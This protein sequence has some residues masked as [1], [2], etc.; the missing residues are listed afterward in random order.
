MRILI[1]SIISGV[2]WCGIALGILLTMH[3]SLNEVSDIFPTY[4]VASLL[5]SYFVT[6]IFRRQ[7][8]DERV[9]RRWW[10]PFAT[11]PA[12]VT[13]WSC[14][15]FLVGFVFSA[16][17]G[18]SLGRPFDGLVFFIFYALIYT[19]TIYLVITYP[20]AYLT[21]VLIG[22]YAKPHSTTRCSAANVG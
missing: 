16:I 7:L 12:G 3:A 20:C 22:R 15:V 5:A 1:A 10:L 18:D 14:F 21:Q 2:V 6:M 11:I 19:L 17:R 9:R 13:L 4:F 8:F